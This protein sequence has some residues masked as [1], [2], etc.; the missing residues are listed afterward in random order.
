MAFI[1]HLT[2][3]CK[4]TGKPTIADTVGAKGRELASSVEEID[5]QASA[6][7]QDILKKIS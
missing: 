5:T 7:E 6:I 2:W 1:F 4:C 3:K